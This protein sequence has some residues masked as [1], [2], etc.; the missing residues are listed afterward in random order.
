VIEP[1]ITTYL[2]AAG[3]ID[4]ALH[5]V[6]AEPCVSRDGALEVDTAAGFEGTQRRQVEALLH[7]V[8]R[9]RVGGPLDDGQAASVDGDG[10]AVTGVAHDLGAADG[11]P[12]RVP[13]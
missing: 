8:G 4:V 1:F 11:Q 9:E 6:P 10:V 13:L 5:D 7:D 2:A 12:H 3:G